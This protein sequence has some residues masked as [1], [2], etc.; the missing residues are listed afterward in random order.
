VLVLPIAARGDETEVGISV[1]PL[2]GVHEEPGELSHIP[3]VPIPILEVAQRFGAFKITL[4]GFPVAPQIVENNGRQTLSTQ[5]AFFDGVAT[6][7]V[8]YGRLAFGGGELIYNQATLYSP[9]GFYVSSRVVGGRYEVSGLPLPNR[10]LRITLDFMPVLGAGVAYRTQSQQVPYASTPEQGSQFEARATYDIPQGRN[11]LRFGLR[12]INYV[13]HFTANGRL[14]DR[15]TGVI[16][17]VGYYWR[18]GR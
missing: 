18:F 17:S 5:L 3:P 12:Y 10:R 8:L 4:E 6:V 1:G 7:D 13:S 16:P 11:V 2:I 9:P 15:N 14:A